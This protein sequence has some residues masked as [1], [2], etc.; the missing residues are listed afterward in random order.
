MSKKPKKVKI[1]LF[2][3]R[4]KKQP[5]EDQWDKMFGELLDVTAVQTPKWVHT[6]ND[7]AK[8]FINSEITKACQRLINEHNLIVIAKERN[9]AL[10]GYTGRKFYVEKLIKSL[11]DTQKSAGELIKKAKKL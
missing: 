11:E 6:M 8:Q 2:E 4:Y 3:K 5:W 9:A 7:F 1:D 10:K